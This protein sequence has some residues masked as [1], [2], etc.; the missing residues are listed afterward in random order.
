[1]KRRLVD[2]DLW[3]NAGVIVVPARFSCCM[4]LHI[5]D[6]GNGFGCLF[7]DARCQEFEPSNHLEELAAKNLLPPGRGPMLRDGPALAIPRQGW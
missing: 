6:T 4:T 1:M 7:A 3:L 5:C 2:Q